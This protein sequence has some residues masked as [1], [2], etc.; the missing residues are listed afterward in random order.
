LQLVIALGFHIGDIGDTDHPE[1][2]K[3]MSAINGNLLSKDIRVVAWFG[4]TGN[5]IIETQSS[6]FSQISSELASAS[7]KTFFVM[8]VAHLKECLAHL[9]RLPMP[10][11]E[12]GIRWTTG[13]SFR[14]EYQTD[15]GQLPEGWSTKNGFFFPF[16]QSVVGVRKRD[17]LLTPTKLDPKHRIPWGAAGKD[18]SCK[19]GGTW[20]SRS[21]RTLQGLLRVCPKG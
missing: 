5:S 1:M 2:T 18:C 14:M 20:T 11:F 21:E 8:S 6:N 7:G 10:M 4:H 15:D 16:S 13:A 19:F 9:A 3:W 17:R 12:D